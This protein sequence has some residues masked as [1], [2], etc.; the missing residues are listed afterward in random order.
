MSTQQQRRGIRHLHWPEIARNGELANQ[1]ESSL[2]R[3]SVE[4]GLHRRA[5]KEEMPASVIKTQDG[6]TRKVGK[7][8]RYFG[9]KQ[10]L[11]LKAKN[12]RVIFVTETFRMKI[13]GN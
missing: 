4:R 3:R 8:S 1:I 10:K 11:K 12:G 13:D 5:R 7:R 9:A 6:M 2:R